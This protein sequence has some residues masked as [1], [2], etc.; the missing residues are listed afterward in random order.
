[1]NFNKVSFL[2]FFKFLLLFSSC[3]AQSNYCYSANQ[4]IENLDI[5][6]DYCRIYNIDEQSIRETDMSTESKT[7]E[8]AI[9]IC[10]IKNQVRFIEKEIKFESGDQKANISYYLSD[11]G[12]IELCKKEVAF[13]EQG[14]FNDE[15]MHYYEIIGIL[16]SR[17]K[18]SC[19]YYTDK[20]LREIEDLSSC[21]L[22]V[23]IPKWQLGLGER[24]MQIED[25]VIILKDR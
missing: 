10:F 24:I 13:F 19:K 18:F 25:L 2:Y 8:N 5:K 1:M 14:C 9:K 12:T 22:N 15:I 21:F 4:Q 6:F 16:K 20:D 3:N 7:N 11:N 17:S 23:N